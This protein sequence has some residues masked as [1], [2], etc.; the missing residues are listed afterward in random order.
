MMTGASDRLCLFGELDFGAS[1]P[2]HRRSLNAVLDGNP[3]QQF[4]FAFLQLFAYLGV[5]LKSFSL[6]L[7]EVFVTSNKRGECQRF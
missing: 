5:H 7:I 2:N 4:P 3:T 6:V 1:W